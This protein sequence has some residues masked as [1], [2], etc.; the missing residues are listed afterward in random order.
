MGS[1]PG[2]TL[3]APLL[4]MALLLAS[5]QEKDMGWPRPD[6]A[7]NV[8]IG[9]QVAC[10]TV[11][12][13]RIVWRTLAHVRGDVEV[14]LP[15]GDWHLAS[16]RDKP[17][18]AHD[19]EIKG[20]QPGAVVEY[21]LLH[22]GA[23]VTEI[24]GFRTPGA[25]PFTFAVIGDTGSGG[26][27]QYD[28]REV[29]TNIDPVFVLHVGDVA[30]DHGS[31]LEAVRRHFT[32]Y[33]DLIATRPWFIA[34]GNHDAMTDGGAPLRD[35]F[36]LPK[37]TDEGSNRY[38]AF[39]WGDM[40]FWALDFTMEWGE[41]SAQ[42]EWFKADLEASRKRWK[43]VFGHYPPYSASPYAKTYRSIWEKARA[44][45][46][47]LFDANGVDLYFSGHTHGYERTHP[48]RGSKRVGRGEGTVYVVCGGGGKRLNLAGTDSWTAKSARTLECMAIDVERDALTA[49][50]IDAS[51]RELDRFTIP[52]KR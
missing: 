10:V 44:D 30:Y 18:R 28:V 40:R 36:R 4:A 19:V 17:G 31:R 20:L 37:S 27:G 24:R 41:G 49:R 11:S 14:R 2:D 42:Y 16:G 48:V 25:T 47:P 34:W 43:I 51:G 35:L 6:F 15:D 26:K 46:C 5:C 50:A 52:S 22:D 13:A 9:P 23:P 21:R 29:L 8:E 7:P 3:L 32:P 45:L 33:R 38:Y 1:S 39:D 12:S